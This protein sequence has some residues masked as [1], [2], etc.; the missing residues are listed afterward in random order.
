MRL[1][2]LTFK[3]DKE[4]KMIIENCGK[5]ENIGQFSWVNKMEVKEIDGKQYYVTKDNRTYLKDLLDKKM[6]EDGFVLEEWKID[7]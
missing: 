2:K 6:E 4:H 1:K 3:N 7:L 5:E